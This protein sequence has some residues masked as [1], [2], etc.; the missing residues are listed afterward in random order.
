MPVVE[1]RA[2]TPGDFEAVFE[3]LTARSIAAVGES[4][5]QRG[6]L[7]LEWRLANTDRF[8]ATDGGVVGYAALD[9]AHD[10]VLA[11]REDDEYDALLDTIERRA[12]QRGFDTLTAI[13]VPQ[14]AS[15]HALVGR[16]GFEHQG[17]VLRMWRRLD[18]G[19]S[20]PAWP[21]DVSIRTYTDEDAPRVRALLDEAY[22][23]WDDAYVARPHDDWLQWM[24]GHDEF[25][26]ALWFLVERGDELV[27]C[28]LHWR[29]HERK[30]WVKDL[31]V[32][33]RDRGRGLGTS[34]LHAGFAEYARRGVDRVGLKV[35]AENPTGA[36][37]LYERV[38][39]V[40]DRRYGM[41]VKPL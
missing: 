23:P 6:H 24:T 32:R 41:W 37:R 33:E 1:I 34:L 7:A 26:P 36:P 18:N 20:A 17:D 29:E 2:S 4:E 39:F 9:G 11:A 27:A 30:G 3:L 28:A 22:A 25:D 19:R 13:V 31:V 12:R 5:L 15:F 35:D 38:G 40:T 14:D 16:A 10:V 8:V 21:G